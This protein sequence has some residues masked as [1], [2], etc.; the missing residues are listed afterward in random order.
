MKKK[1]S[2]IITILVAVATMVAS[3]PLHKVSALSNTL[4]FSPNSGAAMNVGA[5]FTVNVKAYVETPGNPGTVAGTVHYPANILKVIATSTSGSSYG[6]PAISQ[7]SGSVGFSGSTS[8]GPSGLTQVFSITFQAVGGGTAGLSYSGNS[9]INGAAANRNTASFTVNTPPPQPTPPSP[10]PSTPPPPPPQPVVPTPPPAAVETP[11]T[12]TEVEDNTTEDESGF[13]QDVSITA[14]YDKATVTWKHSREAT[15]STLL[16][17]G[18]RTSL[19]NKAQANKQ[20][21]GSYSAILEGL[22]PG[23]RYYFTITSEDAN[24]ATETWDSL[25][26][27]RGYPVVIA[28]TENEA[29]AANATI[30]IG[31]V[32]R[33]TN[34]DGTATIELAEGNYNATI[35]TEKKTIKTV[36]FSVVSKEVPSDGKAPASQRYAFNLESSSGS[37]GGIGGT[38]ILTFIFI[39]FIGGAVLVLG[40]LG[41]LGWRRR[42]YEGSYGGEYKATGPSVIIDDGYNW[43]QQT[44]IAPPPPVAPPPETPRPGTTS[45]DYEEPKDMFELAREREKRFRSDDK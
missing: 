12:P 35:T 32:S 7:S 5:T 26:I 39:L 24:K 14:G 22:K 4:L 42:Q 33:T 36:S 43:Q 23:F 27:A 25:V 11:P 13:I 41:Y 21:D 6:N 28:V 17:G 29:V 10:S 40:V 1:L 3:V 20:A 9:T 30:R 37:G 31:T 8:P 19:D 18:S 15:T 34:K 38:S 2:H 16:Y 44:P 45:Q